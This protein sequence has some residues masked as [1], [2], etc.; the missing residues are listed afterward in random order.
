MPRC[1]P[2]TAGALRGTTIPFAIETRPLR[3]LGTSAEEFRAFWGVLR[4]ALLT[5][6][7]LRFIIH[8]CG[9]GECAEVAR[10]ALHRIDD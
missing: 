2:A 1:R 10:V 9:F 5:K 4:A 7:E 6:C 8:K 3:R